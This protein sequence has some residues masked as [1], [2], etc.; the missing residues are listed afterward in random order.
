[1]TKKDDV[2]TRMG[3]LGAPKLATLFWRV[4]VEPVRPK[5]QTE[6]GIVLPESVRSADRSL[7][8]MGRITQVGPLAF[9]AE[10]KA[11]LNLG[12]DPN[13]VNVRPGMYALYGQYAGQKVCTADEREYVVLNDTDIL[14]LTDRPGEFVNYL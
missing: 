3:A 7:T 12:S 14:A 9:K 11:G 4:L 8:C 13:A 5:E 2:D 1:M 6:G 10:T